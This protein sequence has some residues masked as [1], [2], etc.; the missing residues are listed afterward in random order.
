MNGCSM[1]RNLF[2]LIICLFFSQCSLEK[3]TPKTAPTD[4]KV[5][6]TLESVF[7]VEDSIIL[8]Y[9]VEALPKRIDDVAISDSFVYTIGESPNYPVVKFDR[10]GNF[11]RY[12]GKAGKGPGEI[13]HN[14]WNKLDA[15]GNKLAVLIRGENRVILFEND[16]YK[17]QDR[18]EIYEE[19]DEKHIKDI[20]FLD[21]QNLLLICKDI[22][23]H[24]VL[25]TDD[26]LNIKQRFFKLPLTA[27]LGAINGQ[28][29]YWG[30]QRIPE[31]YLSHFVYPPMWIVFDQ[32]DGKLNLNDKIRSINFQYFPV[33][34]SSLSLY[35]VR[36]AGMNTSE[37]EKSIGNLFWV[38]QKDG[39][40][41]GSYMYYKKG[42]IDAG[43][44]SQSGSVDFVIFVTKNNKILVE[45]IISRDDGIMM[46]PYN[47]YLIKY[48]I[49]KRGDDIKVVLYFLR[50]RPI[51]EE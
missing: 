39:F 9:P 11:I 38:T 50:L 32:I 13:P 49:R 4:R 24:N 12:I 15:M 2:L 28:A 34:D 36:A 27:S 20:G 31:G 14:Y 18:F 8:N 37:I 3:E 33:V 1:L 48:A 7:S 10:A 41:I 25:L 19:N 45:K 23:K 51:N 17:L 22:S 43:N 5:L 40:F 30:I 42:N 47:E 46:L 35:T 21:D 6:G 44:T 26:K 29:F 16:V